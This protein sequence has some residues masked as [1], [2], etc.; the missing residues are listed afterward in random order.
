MNLPRWIGDALRDLHKY[1]KDNKVEIVINSDGI[2]ATE[3]GDT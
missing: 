2:Y 3:E 1:C